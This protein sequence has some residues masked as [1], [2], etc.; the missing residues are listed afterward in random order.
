MQYSI[1]HDYEL[2]LCFIG[3]TFHNHTLYNY[4]KQSRPCEHLSLEEVAGKDQ[5]W[6][7]ARQFMGVVTSVP[8]KKQIADT[9]ADRNI[10]WFSTVTANSHIGHNVKIGYNTFVN[11][12]NVV[13][14]DVVVGDHCTLANHLAIS[15]CVSIGDFCHIS[16]FSYLCFT[17]L[18]DGVCIGLRGTFPGK[19]D[20]RLT[21]ADWSNFML[22][23]TVTESIE[24]SGTYAGKRKQSDDTSLTLKIF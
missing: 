13:Y 10:K 4:F 24:S 14:D 3:N 11:N 6:I 1:I 20:N 21:I 19:P 5:S 7:D 18:G 17:T 2:P 16:P 22:D 9:L 23:S 12:F 15:H 8:F